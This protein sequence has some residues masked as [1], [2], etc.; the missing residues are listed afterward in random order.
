MLAVDRGKT[1]EPRT[2]APHFSGDARSREHVVSC[3]NALQTSESPYATRVSPPSSQD[4]SAVARIATHL[5]IGILIGAGAG[6]VAGAADIAVAGAVT[7]DRNALLAALVLATY[8]FGFGALFGAITGF[9]LAV[10]MLP[11]SARPRLLRRLRWVWGL[12]AAAIVWSLCALFFGAPS[13]HPG[14]NETIATVWS[15]LVW[16]YVIPTALALILGVA[17]GPL[18]ARDDGQPAPGVDSS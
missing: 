18:L 4:T 7:A 6:A 8:G 16:F 9:A 11:L 1:P 17:L 3:A 13:L 10:I 12:C 15:D 5:V 14:P 2:C